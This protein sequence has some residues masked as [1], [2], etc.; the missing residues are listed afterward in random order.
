MADYF[1]LMEEVLGLT[2]AHELNPAFDF[3][4]VGGTKVLGH[5]NHVDATSME[6]LMGAD[7]GEGFETAPLILGIVGGGIIEVGGVADSEG[8]WGNE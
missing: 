4:G 1:V 7:L 6:S 2:S 5:A 8:F 3:L